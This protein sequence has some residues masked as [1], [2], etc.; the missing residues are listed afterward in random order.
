MWY[1]HIQWTI[2]YIYMMWCDDGNDSKNKH[3]R[4]S[5]PVKHISASE[6]KYHSPTKSSITMKFNRKPPENQRHITINHNKHILKAKGRGKAHAFHVEWLLFKGH[7]SAIR[8][9]LNA[10]EICCS[11]VAQTGAALKQLLCGAETLEDWGCSRSYLWYNW[12]K[13]I[14]YDIQILS[15]IIDIIHEYSWYNQW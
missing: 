9:P 6:K 10:A 14:Y 5:P 13:W 8:Q 12:Y 2:Y 4:S 11:D 7:H 1:S 15:I 3:I